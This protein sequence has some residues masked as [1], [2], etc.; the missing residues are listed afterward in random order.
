MFTNEVKMIKRLLAFLLI[1]STANAADVGQLIIP[2]WPTQVISASYTNHT[3]D[4]ATDQI[5]YMFQCEEACAIDALCVRQG[6]TTGTPPTYELRLE[7]ASTAGRADGTVKSSTNAKGDLTL[8]GANAVGCATLTSSYT[9]TKGEFLAGVIDYRTGTIDGSNNAGFT[10]QNANALGYRYPMTWTVDAGTATYRAGIQ[11]FSYKCGSTYYGFLPETSG[12]FDFG[13]GSNPDERGN[14]FTIPASSCSTFKI[15]GA[16]WNGYM[17]ASGS[18]LEVSIYEGTTARQNTALDTDYDT[19]GGSAGYLKVDFDE[20]YT[21]DCGTEYIV[22]I[23]PNSASGV[24]TGL[25]YINVDTNAGLN[26]MPLGTT[27][28]YIGRQDAG[29]WDTTDTTRRAL[30]DL[31]VSDI[32]EPSGGGVTYSRGTGGNKQ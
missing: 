24:S 14:K 2:A 17:N 19:S 26:S 18:T 12:Q 25:Q 20:S 21:F 28:S 9:C 27:M 5:E 32:T 22:A 29:S 10:Y 6:T 15:D 3:L 31:Y 13:S 30:I 16:R 1:A 4:G 11:T 8:P 23:K 7:G